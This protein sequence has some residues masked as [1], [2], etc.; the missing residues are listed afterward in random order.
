M[1]II[2]IGQAAFGNDALYTLIQQ[3]ETIVGVLTVPD[4]A[5]QV[6]PVKALAEANH[7][8]V[9][10]P[11]KLKAPEAVEWVRGLQPDLLVLAFVTDFV[12]DEMIE[13]STKGGINYHPSLLPK[14]RGGSAMNWAIIGGESET[15]VTIHQIDAG[16]DTGPIILQ[17]KV[18][19]DPDDT[20][21]SLYFK[22]LYPLGIQMI[23]DAVR[24]TREESVIPVPQD[25]SQASFQP[26]IKETDVIIDWTRSTK[27]VYNLIRG[28]NPSPGAT[29]F[30]RGE[31]LKIWEGKPYSSNGQPGEIIE[32][33]T[34]QGFVVA[35]GGGAILAQR[36]QY[37]I[38]GKISA[39]EFT[40]KVSLHINE[41]LGSE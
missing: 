6:N 24:L 14:Y 4:R 5:G 13:I 22:K 23:A 30:L 17:E 28:S 18:T 15:G 31:K 1:R 7:L 41:R 32:I 33:K 25:H 12:P 35:T 34:D 8:P 11:A 20:L 3:G 19:I 38:T 9:L 2:F 40:E 21:K 39:N 37:R 27:T 29:T 26:V 10:Q 36:V 16:V